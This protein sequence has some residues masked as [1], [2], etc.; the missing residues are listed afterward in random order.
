MI[1]SAII[2][3]AGLGT[4][5]LPISRVIPKEFL[6]LGDKPLLHYVV[7]EAKSC[8]VRNCIFIVRPQ[9]QKIIAAYFSSPSAV[10]KLLRVRKREHLASEL[11]KIQELKEGLSFSFVTQKVPSGDAHALSLALRVVRQESCAVLFP[12]DIIMAKTP[13]LTQ[14]IHIFRTA[15]KPL[16]ALKKIERKEVGQYGIV[17]TES[18]TH[19]LYK[20]KKIVEKPKPDE[21]PSELAIVGRFV[22]TSE[23]F[24]YLRKIKKYKMQD[25]ASS[26]QE[27][28]LS[29][30]LDAMVHDGKTLYG[31][32]V[33]GEWLECG[34]KQKWM[35][36]SLCY[37]L[38]HS[39]RRQEMRQYA[40]EFL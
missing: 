35:R 25:S 2:P 36:S 22:F 26:S 1:Q 27:F 7:E 32:E 33:E 23:V 8:G 37:L 6:P 30:V 40:K 5:F 39:E 20:I 12:D 24:E 9:Q 38:R 21:A 16:L 10:E 18:I 34:T 28:M 31:Y 3:I 13:C 29:E 14:L 19:R 4:R 17:E 15:Q 11:K